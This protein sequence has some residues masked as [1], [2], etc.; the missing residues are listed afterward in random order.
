MTHHIIIGGGPAAT[1]AIETIRKFEGEPSQITLISDEPAHSRMALPYWLSGQ[2]PREH[3]HT[4]DDAYFEKLG[5]ETR[6]G[7]RVASIDPSANSV[8]LDDG[9]TLSFDNLLIAT[10]ASPAV[11]PIPG[12]DLP[13]VQP[14]WTLEHTQ[15]A[16]DAVDGNAKPR[17]VL[18]CWVHRFHH[19]QC[20]V[21][22]RLAAFG[23]RNRKTNLAA[24][25]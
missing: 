24:D 1:N 3:T 17:V 15:A 11:P 20:D 21:Q 12:A 6:F 2:I 22:T 5:V 23:R 16:L 19:A 13:G 10:G 18:V 14:L 4:G 25:A 8:T 9:N 7:R